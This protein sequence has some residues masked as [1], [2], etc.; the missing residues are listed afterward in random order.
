MWIDDR[1]LERCDEPLALQ[2]WVP[3]SPM[4]VLGASN[5]VDIEVN[6]ANCLRKNIPI[7]KR[8]GGG[9]TV[10]LY[11]GCVVLSLGTWVR[12]D[13]QNQFYFQHLNRAF[14]SVLEK[15]TGQNQLHQDGVSDI[16][17]GSKKLVGTS[18]FRS[19]NY[20]LYQASLLVHLDLELIDECLQHPS[21]EPEYRKGRSHGSFLKGFDTY[22]SGLSVNEVA[23]QTRLTYSSFLKESMGS[24]LISPIESQFK[25]ILQR[26][27]RGRENAI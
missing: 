5:Q 4:V 7:L 24:E 6:A 26:A 11:P 1:I 3:E 9:G 21:R 16:V 8:Y 18:L 22:N 19:R 13:F 15:W 10:V 17:G 23:E 2:A 12:Q 25:N 20:L 14:I 27:K